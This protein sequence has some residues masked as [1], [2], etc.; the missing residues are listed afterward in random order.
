MGVSRGKHAERGLAVSA[1]ALMGLGLAAAAGLVLAVGVVAQGLGALGIGRPDP[2]VE[3]R[4]AVALLPQA[5]GETDYR[6]IENRARAVLDR[7]P[8]QA[9]ALS[10]MATARDRRG[11]SGEAGRLIDAAGTLSR[12]DNVANLW[13]FGRAMERADYETAL[14]HADALMRRDIDANRPVMAVIVSAARDPAIIEPLAKRLALSPSWRNTFFEFTLRNPLPPFVY[15]LFGAMQAQGAPPTAGEMGA[16]LG[17][18]VQAGDYE[19]AYLAW[20]LSLSSDGLKDLAYVYDGTFEGRETIPP[21]GWTFKTGAGGLAVIEDAPGGGKALLVN[22][23]GYTQADFATQLV[24]LAPGVYRLTGRMQGSQRADAGGLGWT[25]ICEV[26][27]AVLLDAPAQPTNGRWRPFSA[28]FTVPAGCPAQKLKLRSGSGAGR[29]ALD[30]WYDDLA[31]APAREA[32][33]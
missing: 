31:I 4:E 10:L 22:S 17:R 20:L 3:L 33:P 2:S 29:A 6:A 14:S 26:S 9:R 25:L 12:R 32:Q 7:S 16:Y 19:Q 8:L 15:S 23:N 21:F 28:V 11:R 27:G 30:V 5:Q 13:L 24:V 1:P 18:L